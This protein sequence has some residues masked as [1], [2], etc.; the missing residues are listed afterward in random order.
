MIDEFHSG[1][2]LFLCWVGWA[3]VTCDFCFFIFIF[4]KKVT[5]EFSNTLF[6]FSFSLKNDLLR[7]SSMIGALN[8]V[9]KALFRAS[10]E[11][12]NI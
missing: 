10:M 8:M 11:N 5:C 12:T 9:D 2:V 6:C 7:P 3:R 4:F 1:C